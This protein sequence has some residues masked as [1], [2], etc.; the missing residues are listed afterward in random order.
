[1]RGKTGKKRGGKFPRSEKKKTAESE[2][3]KTIVSGES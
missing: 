1:M 2:K 3:Q